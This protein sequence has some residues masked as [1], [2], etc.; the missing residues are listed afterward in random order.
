MAAYRTASRRTHL[1]RKYRPLLPLVLLMLVAGCAAGA[2]ELVGTPAAIGRPAGFLYGLWHG[3]IS[4][5]AFISSFFVE[6][7]GIYEVHNNGGWYDLGFLLGASS[8]LGGSGG[9]AARRRR[10]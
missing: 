1:V 3:L 8:V 7:V 9:S 5:F 2:N 10:R 6:N 4:P